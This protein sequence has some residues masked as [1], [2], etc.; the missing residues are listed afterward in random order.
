M[1]DGMFSMLRGNAWLPVDASLSLANVI[2][3]DMENLAWIY[4]RTI[5]RA[6][7]Y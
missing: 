5:G 3:L 7:C 2:S 4:L 6:L 1:T